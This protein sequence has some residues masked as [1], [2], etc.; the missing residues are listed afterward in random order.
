[1]CETRQRG[2]GGGG[3]ERERWGRERGECHF[4]CLPDDSHPPHLAACTRLPANLPAC[5]LTCQLAYLNHRLFFTSFF[6]S[7]VS[8][9]FSLLFC[10]C[11]SLSANLP[12]CFDHLLACL[13]DLLFFYF[14]MY[15]FFALFCYCLFILPASLPACFSHLPS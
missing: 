13:S 9:V 5:L 15:V 12:V 10:Y 11:L 3:G 4:A 1:M 7:C 8:V 14:F 6:F 2:G